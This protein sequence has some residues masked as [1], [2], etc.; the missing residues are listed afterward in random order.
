[1]ECHGRR[2]CAYIQG[3][4]PIHIVL[5]RCSARAAARGS[6]LPPPPPRL[7]RSLTLQGTTQGVPPH[8]KL[9]VWGTGGEVGPTQAQ[10]GG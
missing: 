5:I 10:G 8:R 3:M 1:M 6:T 9:P 2:E 7:E 4:T